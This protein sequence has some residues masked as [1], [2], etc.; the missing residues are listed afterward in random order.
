MKTANKKI[1][2]VGT[3]F[4]GMSFA[5]SLLNQGIGNELVLIDVNHEKAEGEAMDLNHGLAFAPSNMAI[6]AGSYDECANADIVVITAGIPQ[7]DG[8]TRLDL[9]KVNA[10]V[11]RKI[12]REVIA[13]GFDGVFL[14]ATNPVDVLTQVVL[15][16]SKWTRNRVFGSGCT[17]DTARLRHEIGKRLNVDSRNIHGFV[18]G[19]HGDS[20]FVAWSKMTVSVKPI[21]DVIEESPDLDWSDLEEIHSTVKNAAYEI[22]R[23]KRATF[24]GIGMSLARVVKAYLDDEN[25][26]LPIS[27]FVE[28]E[29]PEAEGVCIG[30]PTKVNR[31]GAAEILKIKLN[32]EEREKLA[33]SASI[34][35]DSLASVRI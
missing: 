34:L 19:E 2:L 27:M 29:F 6:R 11:M 1:V 9:L 15:E 35:R 28:D 12:T 33:H 18:L 7:K 20:E 32:N 23:R 30:L 17:L 4:V 5:Y 31:E 14:V 13:S 8:Q 26:I 16:E 24:Y 3:G 21:A 25:C 10:E 22:I